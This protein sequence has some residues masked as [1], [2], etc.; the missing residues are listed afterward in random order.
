MH[1]CQTNI[2]NSTVFILNIYKDPFIQQCTTKLVTSC[3]SNVIKIRVSVFVHLTYPYMFVCAFEHLREEHF[4]EWLAGYQVP[5]F[6]C[7]SKEAG[8][9]ACP[10]QKPS[11]AYLKTKSTVHHMFPFAKIG[12]IILFTI[13]ESKSS[14]KMMAC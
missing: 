8:W 2:Y 13:Q 5:F 1:F 14:S 6:S 9:V 10:I 11:W 12:E 4:S 7:C 3:H